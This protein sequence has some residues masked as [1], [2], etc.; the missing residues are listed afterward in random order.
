LAEM[1]PDLFFQRLGFARLCALHLE[2]ADHSKDDIE[3]RPDYTET[4]SSYQ[5]LPLPDQLFP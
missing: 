4:S 5:Y 3:L 1:M 2:I